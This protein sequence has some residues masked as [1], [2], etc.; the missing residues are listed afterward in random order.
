MRE[1]LSSIEDM[2]EDASTARVETPADKVT[3]YELTITASGTV[4]Q[5]TAPEGDQI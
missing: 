4:G 1:I 2:S 3:K 5:G